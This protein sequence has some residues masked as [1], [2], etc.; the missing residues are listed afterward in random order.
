MDKNGKQ[1]SDLMARW[2]RELEKKLYYRLKKR[3]NSLAGHLEVFLAKK[4][5]KKQR[6]KTIKYSDKFE[7]YYVM[8]KEYLDKYDDGLS[9]LTKVYKTV[10]PEIKL[11][12]HYK[13]SSDDLVNPKGKITNLVLFEEDENK[14]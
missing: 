4:N 1:M 10:Q 8:Y 12:K 5:L 9:R 6:K 13:I 14:E 3:I 11:K 7:K 2:E